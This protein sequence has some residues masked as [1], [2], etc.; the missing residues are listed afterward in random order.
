M[1]ILFQSDRIDFVAVTE[2]LIPDYLEM[3]NDYEHVAKLISDRIK[4][5]TTEDEQRWV[6]KKLEER[7]LV[8][9]MIERSSGMFIGNIELMDPKEGSAELG[10]AIT[11]KKQDQGFG[12]ESIG[13]I[14]LHAFDEL[15]LDQV[16]LRVFP[17]NK[18][19]I[20]VYEAC[21]FLEYNRSETD[22]YMKVLRTSQE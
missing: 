15:D 12:K 5:Y 1:A 6:R 16:T 14:L 3:V 13:R 20:H 2:G 19:A 9:S 21:G 8:F 11:A 18:R 4:T 10:I 22:V 17:G 7:A